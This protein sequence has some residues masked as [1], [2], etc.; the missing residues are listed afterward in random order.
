[1]TQRRGGAAGRAGPGAPAG[2]GV[3]SAGGRPDG[4]STAASPGCGRRWEA[5]EARPRRGDGEGRSSRDVG[6]WPRKVA[7]A[8]GGNRREGTAC[9]PDCVLGQ[10]AE[11]SAYFTLL[12]VHLISRPSLSK[13]REKTKY[14]FMCIYTLSCRQF[15]FWEPNL[16]EFC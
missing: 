1:M 13:A 4:A 7:R 14:T 2:P 10:G 16:K 8:V 9:A 12:K 6:Q 11:G 15:Y 5:G 3:R